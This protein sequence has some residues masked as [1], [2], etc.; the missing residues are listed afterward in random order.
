[1]YPREFVSVFSRWGVME[2]VCMYDEV[3]IVLENGLKGSSLDL[4]FRFRVSFSWDGRCKMQIYLLEGGLS[5]LLSPPAAQTKGSEAASFWEVNGQEWR[6]LSPVKHTHMTLPLEKI[7]IVQIH[8][9]KKTFLQFSHLT[10]SPLVVLAIFGCA[11]PSLS[12]KFFS[13]RHVCDTILE[14]R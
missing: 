12:K 2:W 6:N 11:Y 8:T 14:L 10:C 5:I 4:V 13:A 9:Q 3:E 1:M 7:Q